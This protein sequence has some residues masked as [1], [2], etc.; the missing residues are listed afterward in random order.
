MTLEVVTYELG[1]I[2]PISRMRLD[3]TLPPNAST[4][5][6]NAPL[7]GQEPRHSEAV[8]PRPIVVSARVLDAGG[9]VLA[10]TANWPEPYKFL[11]LPEPGLRL[12]VAGDEV[13]VSSTA[14]LK[15]LVLD[16]PEADLQFSDQ[17][18][19]VFPHDPQ[20]VTARGLNGRKVT[21]QYLKNK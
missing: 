11:T 12:D 10:R 2:A 5:V 13:T 20:T 3:V 21:A 4:E 17:A 14:P 9:K 7:P 6:S 18:L 1:T 19:D 15:G 16:A 8:P